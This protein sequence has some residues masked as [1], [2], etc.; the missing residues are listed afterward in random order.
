MSIR[1]HFLTFGC[2]LALLGG[3]AGDPEPE[4]EP[5]PEPTTGTETAVE[6]NA[7]EQAWTAPADVQIE[8]DHITI[9]GH[10]N[11][12]SDSDVILADSNELL[13]H[14]ADVVVHHPEIHHLRII[15]HTDA[16]G[17][18]AHN[19]D[20]SERRA[21]AVLAALQERGV[22]IDLRSSGVGEDEPV[23]EEDTDEC[24]AQNRRVEFLIV[25]DEDAEAMGEEPVEG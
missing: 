19:Q 12:E 20:L 18:P 25:S 6:V 8:G 16:A 21:A 13:D 9:D 7:P 15:G 24:H 22:E 5:E 23:C 14:I 2:A 10:I 1:K 4:P 11:F 3:C 17:G